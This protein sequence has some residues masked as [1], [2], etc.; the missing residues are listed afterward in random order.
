MQAAKISLSPDSE[1][2]L[3]EIKDYLENYLM[4]ILTKN[5]ADPLD[6]FYRLRKEGSEEK[7]NA[8][9]EGASKRLTTPY[10][11]L[12][13]SAPFTSKDFKET[14]NK[15]SIPQ[16]GV[17]E[18]S[19]KY[20]ADILQGSTAI[21]AIGMTVAATGV[22]GMIMAGSVGGVAITAVDVGLSSV[23][24][25]LWKSKITPYI[26]KKVREKLNNKFTQLSNFLRIME[27]GIVK[28]YLSSLLRDENKDT[29]D[30]TVASKIE[31]IS[32]A[33]EYMHA[34][35]GG[36]KG[37]DGDFYKK[38][39][40][41]V[42]KDIEPKLRTGIID[43]EELL[44]IPEKREMIEHIRKEM[45]HIRES[46]IDTLLINYSDASNRDEHIH[47]TGSPLT[48]EELD[49]MIKY[50]KLC[51]EIYTDKFT[52]WFYQPQYYP[53]IGNKLNK[54]IQDEERLEESYNKLSAISNK[55]SSNLQAA[56]PEERKA[57]SKHLKNGQTPAPPINEQL[58]KPTEDYA[59]SMREINKFLESINRQPIKC[60]NV[61]HITTTMG[62][63]SSTH[64]DIFS[65]FLNYFKISKE[66]STIHQTIGS[67]FLSYLKAPKGG[68]ISEDRKYIAPPRA[69]GKK[70]KEYELSDRAIVEFAFSQNTDLFQDNIT[71]L[72]VG[73][74]NLTNVEGFFAKGLKKVIKPFKYN[75]TSRF[76]GGGE[77]DFIA[78]IEEDPVHERDKLFIVY[79]G[80]NSDVD[81][82]KN[83][84]GG[85]KRLD[86]LNLHA[87]ICNLFNESRQT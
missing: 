55:I 49:K 72:D 71:I 47:L 27:T 50:M 4:S 9:V 28:G 26:R 15:Y 2:Y 23:E 76:D 10:S 61:D 65:Q 29:P 6:D 83:L 3:K 44:N 63:L 11:I 53:N 37:D 60:K 84:T 86:D 70:Q 16:P 67:Q 39:W 17:T 18:K 82:V 36:G 81:W 32:A 8:L 57:R 64:I 43:Q 77:V 33:I 59:T 35:L 52:K 68:L 5:I 20:I 7:V 25:K 13:A 58:S 31:T 75:P 74:R 38:I 40:Y 51:S 30:K 12:R 87:G 56:S 41:P 24:K 73:F 46:F 1:S 54:I 69:P 85:Y 34:I 42:F 66:D 79:S 78:Y 45:P 48:E 62:K 14:F 19:L 22:P 80:S 21:T